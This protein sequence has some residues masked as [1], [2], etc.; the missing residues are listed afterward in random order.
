MIMMLGDS[1]TAGFDVAKYFPGIEIVNKGISGDNTDLILARLTRD[2]VD[3]RP[4][5]LFILIG[6]NDMACLFTNE[7]TIANYEMILKI[8][9]EKLPSTELTV[10]SILPT[11]GLENRPIPGICLL[12]NM[13]EAAAKKY[14]AVYL[15]LTPIF[16]GADGCI[17][18]AL[19]EDG[20]H[21]TEDGYALWAA[22]LRKVFAAC[23]SPQ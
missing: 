19:S 16:S 23:A 9:R 15:D 18:E 13:I 10:Q 1:I 22:H 11:R 14:N 6:T 21:L 4:D 5:H 2:V 3:V 12:N 20:L 7:K 8:L 17:P